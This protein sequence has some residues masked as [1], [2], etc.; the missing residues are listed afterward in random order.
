MMEIYKYIHASSDFGLLIERKA[1]SVRDPTQGFQC[2]YLVTVHEIFDFVEHLTVI[3][4]SR[5]FPLGDVS[6]DVVHLQGKAQGME[7]SPFHRAIA[8]QPR[9]P[10]PTLL[11]FVIQTC[12]CNSDIPI[13]TRWR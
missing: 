2:P 1:R 12:R 7:W 11:A 3:H 4:D 10:F 5:H 13:A 9:P 6:A 8:P